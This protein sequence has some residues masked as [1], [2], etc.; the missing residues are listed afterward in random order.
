MENSTD[1]PKSQHISLALI[2]DTNPILSDLHNSN[3]SPS[4][5]FNCETATRHLAHT[6]F[7][8]FPLA[9]RG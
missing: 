8:S 7:C 4:S 1:F 9:M 6:I 2:R 3:D 5:A